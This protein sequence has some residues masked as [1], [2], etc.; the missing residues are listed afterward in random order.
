MITDFKALTIPEGEVVKIEDSQGRVLWQK[1]SPLPYDAEIEYLEGTGTQFIELPIVI[2]SLD[3]T[4]TV[5]GY[6]SMH[7]NELFSVN[8]SRTEQFNFETGATYYRWFT[9]ASLNAGAQLSV[10]NTWVCNASLYRNGSIVGTLT[11]QSARTS[12]PVYIFKG[13]HGVAKGR[14]W[15]FSTSGAVGGDVDLI[16][17]RVGTTGYMYDKVSGQLFGNAGTGSFGL[18]PDK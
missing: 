9:N 3:S 12:T 2:S 14:V 17:V 5:D 4:I 6:V 11:D 8:L 16:P 10:R 13:L 18:G 7:N 1:A 15:S